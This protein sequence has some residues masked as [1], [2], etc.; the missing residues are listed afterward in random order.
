M[1]PALME[2]QTR[3]S[4]NRRNGLGLPSIVEVKPGH[5]GPG[6]VEQLILPSDPIARRLT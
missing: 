3:H 5:V 4:L 2:R 1:A 6:R